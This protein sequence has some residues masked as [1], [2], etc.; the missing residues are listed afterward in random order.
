MER[1]IFWVV[2][3]LSISVAMAEVSGAGKVTADFGR[4]VASS[5]GWYGERRTV[6][7]AAILLFVGA[8]TVLAA[9]GWFMMSR[10]APRLRILFLEW[11]AL[12]TFLGARE[13]SLHQVD[14]IV[15]RP[16]VGELTLGILLEVGFVCL[17]GATVLILV[18]FRHRRTETG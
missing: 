7:A 4:S 3:M 1:R 12:S 6:Q 9:V 17:M 14:T 15:N 11:I 2:A 16:I 8:S 10:L 5:Q 18:S 13:V